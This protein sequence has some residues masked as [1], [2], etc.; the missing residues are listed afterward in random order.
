MSGETLEEGHEELVLLCSGNGKHGFSVGKK[1]T[2][3]ETSSR[4]AL[5]F[6]CEH[7]ESALDAVLGV[8]KLWMVLS[9]DVFRLFLIH[10]G[11]C[12]V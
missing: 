7:L 6:V 9:L 8:K 4:P 10:L 12:Q 2:K 3:S 1:L 5:S 11:I